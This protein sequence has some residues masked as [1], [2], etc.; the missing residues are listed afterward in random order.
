MKNFIRPIKF[1]DVFFFG[2]FSV[3]CKELEN[4]RYSQ[5][6]VEL[7]KFL[8]RLNFFFWVIENSGN[9]KQCGCAACES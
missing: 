2:V 9:V 6:V 8:G 4:W 5:G 1:N 7:G 3:D